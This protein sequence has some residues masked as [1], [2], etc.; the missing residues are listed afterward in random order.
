MKKNV[1]NGITFPPNRP[2]IKPHEF[3]DGHTLRILRRTIKEARDVEVGFLL[4]FGPKGVFWQARPTCYGSPGACCT[5]HAAFAEIPHAVVHN[6]PGVEGNNL[7]PSNS[8]IEVAQR[9]AND[10]VAYYI[11]DNAVSVVR[12]VIPLCVAWM[13]R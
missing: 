12:V 7:F 4:T 1:F 3:A 11:T 5:R 9:I 10:G 2:F 8:D 13:Y 6:H